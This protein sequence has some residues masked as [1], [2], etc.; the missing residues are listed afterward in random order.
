MNPTER[1]LERAVR[2]GDEIILSTGLSGKSLGDYP[3]G[4]AGEVRIDVDGSV[5]TDL[6]GTVLLP[7]KD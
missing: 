3:A 4:Y 6:A 2:K 1:T 5:T 7:K